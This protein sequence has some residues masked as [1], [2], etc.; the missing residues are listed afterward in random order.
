MGRGTAE[1][2]RGSRPRAH[3][4]EPLRH[5][6]FAAAPPPRLRQGGDFR[7][8]SR[9]PIPQ[10]FQR[11]HRFPDRSPRLASPLPHTGRLSTRRTPWTRITPNT[12]TGPATGPDTIPTTTPTGPA[13]TT[14]APAFSPSGSP[15][16][17]H[18]VAL[19]ITAP[20]TPPGPA[21]GPTIWRGSPPRSSASATAC[22]SRRS[23]TAPPKRAGVV[24]TSP[25][26]N[27]ST[28]RPSLRR[29]CPTMPTWPTTP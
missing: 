10:L 11:P 25:G 13:S 17:A 18:P 5:V 7:S 16:H 29:A 22:A 1:R 14:N 20:P 24:R 21:P 27:R 4:E 26:P 9:H 28:S 12:A 8:D 2:W 3:P 6:G 23:G 15:G 19:A